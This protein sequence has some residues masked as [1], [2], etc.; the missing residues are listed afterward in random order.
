M[1]VIGIRPEHL[2]PAHRGRCS[3]GPMTSLSP[4]APGR[5]PSRNG[6]SGPA[7]SCAAVPPRASAAGR[8][9]IVAHG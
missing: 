9:F 8:K 1:L 7:A 6:S 3:G 4:S 5:R 2:S